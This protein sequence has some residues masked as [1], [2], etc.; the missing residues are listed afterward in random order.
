MWG[1]GAGCKWRVGGGRRDWGGVTRGKKPST[2]KVYTCTGFFSKACMCTRSPLCSMAYAATVLLPIVTV[3]SRYLFGLSLHV[4]A[5]LL[6][7]TDAENEAACSAELNSAEGLMAG[8][9]I[10][11]SHP[12][13]KND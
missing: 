6:A 10:Y 9:F 1:E 7:T 4:G 2:L 11:S 13:T 12:L 3:C 8:D 5:L